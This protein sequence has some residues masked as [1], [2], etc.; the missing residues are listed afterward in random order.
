MPIG[1]GRAALVA[2]GALLISHLPALLSP[3]PIQD[4]SVYVIVAR[5]LLRGDRLYVDI[6]DRKPPLLYWTYAA[7]LDLFGTHGWLALHLVGVLWV[8]AT[9]AALY[10]AGTL[11]AGES[12]GLIAAVLYP[13]FQSFW[14]VT[15]L[16]FNGEVLMNLPVL[17]A[18]A[19]AFRDSRSKWRPELLL[20]GALPALGAL[21]KQPA[22]ISALPLGL[23][24]LH[25]GYRRARG[26]GIGDSI[27]QGALLTLGYLATFAV[28]GWIFQHQGTL[29]ETVYWSVG[30]HDLTYGPLSPVFWSRGSRMVLIFSLC[31]A[32]LLYGAWRSVR[33]PSLWDWR[34]PER[35]ALLAFLGVTAIGTASSG[36]FFDYYFIQ[37]LPPLCLLAAPWYGR[38]WRERPAS[39]PARAALASVALCA[40]VFLAVNL[41]ELPSRLGEPPLARYIRRHSVPDDRF[42]LWG[43]SLNYYLRADLR[44][45]SRYL[46]YFPLTG[47]IFGSPWNR[48]PAH[49]DTGDRILPGAWTNLQR[50]FDQHPPRYI[51]DTEASYYPP[52]YPIAHFPW[53]RDLIASRY[54]LVYTAPQGR[55][56]ERRDSSAVLTTRLLTTALPARRGH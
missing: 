49:E 38:L 37:L 43:P 54:R 17:L 14:E 2:G 36:R 33:D 30:N 50:D 21:L 11:V 4:E 3:A 22:A 42:Y 23:Y 31:C 20:A 45:A 18:F 24:L 10:L 55:L 40:L 5:E 52:K 51:L 48:D 19:L 25:P 1:R 16:A 28:A 26:L 53:L 8:A 15:N 56:Y 12:A 29:P 44:P 34:Q 41:A 9:M 6:I 27:R 32:P 35:F 13:V 7:I 39:R 46:G 47:Y